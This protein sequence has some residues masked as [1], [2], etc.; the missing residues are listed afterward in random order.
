MVVAAT[1]LIF[2]VLPVAAAAS[3]DGSIA[4]S[5]AGSELD[6]NGWSPLYPSV[7]PAMRSLCKDPVAFGPGNAP[8][9]FEDNGWYVGHDEPGVG[10]ISSTPGSANTMT[11]YI[12]LPVDPSKAP[13][14]SGSVTH[15][16]ELSVAPWVGLVMCDPRGRPY[17]DV[18][19]ATTVGGSSAL[20]D[21]T[22]GAGCTVPPISAA[23]YPYWSLSEPQGLPRWSAGTCVWDFGGDI[24]GVTV[25]DLGG[26]A[27]YGSPD[28]AAYGRYNVSAV[29]TNPA[30]E[31]SCGRH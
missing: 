22:T 1:S 16:G 2:A 17:P 28:P 20:C 10:F 24:P 15:Y 18:Q 4:P 5:T 9:W 23:F 25:N 13:T 12:Q 26:D 11:Y 21:T 29:E 30:T 19:F 8:E 14:A 31:P 3:A 7:R 27:Q 6:C